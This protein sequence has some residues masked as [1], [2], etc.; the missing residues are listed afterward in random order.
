LWLKHKTGATANITS[1]EIANNI[2][3]AESEMRKQLPVAQLIYLEPDIVRT[4]NA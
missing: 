1:Q 4:T 3:A 2:D